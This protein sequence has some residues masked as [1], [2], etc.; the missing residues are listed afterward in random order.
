TTVNPEPTEKVAEWRR[1]ELISHSPHSSSH[2]T[3]L[4]HSKAVQE[5]ASATCSAV[6]RSPPCVSPSW[7]LT[8]SAYAEKE[9]R[10]DVRT[11]L[12]LV[13]TVVRD[14][15]ELALPVFM[16]EPALVLVCTVEVPAMVV[17]VLV[18]T[19]EVLVALVLG[20]TVE[21]PDMVVLVLGCLVGEPATVALVLGSELALA[22]RGV[23]N[24]Y[25]GAGVGGTTGVGAGA[26]VGGGVEW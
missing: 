25:G 1:P 2:R 19:V 14:S 18:C 16:V 8:N 9:G 13:C 24:G 21:A 10:P 20:C 23:G 6:A 5:H 22:V 15:M 3:A 7:A 17:L 4:V 26:G 12:A 11:A